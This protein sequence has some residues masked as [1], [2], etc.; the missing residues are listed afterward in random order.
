MMINHALC[1][2]HESFL[3][4][5]NNND[6]CNNYN[7]SRQNEE[8]QDIREKISYS[9]IKSKFKDMFFTVLGGSNGFINRRKL[10]VG[11]RFRNASKF[12]KF[13]RLSEWL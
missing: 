8:N 12:D 10:N 5:R 2:L 4:L 11:F 6:S 9:N 1:D 7:N 13:S 3:S